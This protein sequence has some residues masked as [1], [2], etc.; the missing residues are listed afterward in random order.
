[1]NILFID[2]VFNMGI[3]LYNRA[4]DTVTYENKSYTYHKT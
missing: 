1:M 2:S 4:T 3:A